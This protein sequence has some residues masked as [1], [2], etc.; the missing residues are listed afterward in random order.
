MSWPWQ[1]GVL[2]E[3]AVVLVC[4]TLGRKVT[5]TLCAPENVGCS[6]L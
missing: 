2:A 4:L 1:L 3:D 5:Q 6:S